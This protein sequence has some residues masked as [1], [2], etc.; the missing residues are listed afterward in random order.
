MEEIT[1]AVVAELLKKL[2]PLELLRVARMP[3][4]ERLSGLPQIRLSENILNGFSKY[5]NAAS[6]CASRTRC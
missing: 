1:D 6:A 5:P 3:E 4:A 2:S